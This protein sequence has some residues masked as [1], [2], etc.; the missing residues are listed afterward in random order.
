MRT[1]VKETELEGS[2]GRSTAAFHLWPLGGSVYPAKDLPQQARSHSG[3][4]RNKG[5]KE[6]PF[7]E[8]ELEQGSLLATFVWGGLVVDRNSVQQKI[9]YTA[10]FHEVVLSRTQPPAYGSY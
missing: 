3:L 7:S 8:E 2:I 4:L 10:S 9:I 5:G 6:V 1:R